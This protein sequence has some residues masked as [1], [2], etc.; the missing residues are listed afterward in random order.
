MTR[1]ILTYLLDQTI[2]VALAQ[3][4][5][6]WPIM[7]YVKLFILKEVPQLIYQTKYLDHSGITTP[8]DIV[9]A[10][11]EG[12]LKLQRLC[13]MANKLMEI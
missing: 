2:F 4:S 13:S 5:I 9:T 1:N 6:L 10:V 7:G 3:V 11:Q 8:Q 12:K